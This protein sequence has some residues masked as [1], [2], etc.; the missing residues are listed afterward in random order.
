ME[1][2][3]YNKSIND[4]RSVIVWLFI[5]SFCS[6]HIGHSSFGFSGVSVESIFLMSA[7]ADDADD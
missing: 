7:D 5:K 4:S 3:L 2:K 1:P 6:R